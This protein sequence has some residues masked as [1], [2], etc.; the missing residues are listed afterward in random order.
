MFLNRH[1]VTSSTPQHANDQ[2]ADVSMKVEP[3]SGQTAAFP[4]GMI[5]HRRAD[6]RL[7]G[8]SGSSMMRALELTRVSLQCY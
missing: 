6:Q 3:E 7:G 2:V 4:T 8:T 1:F 5:E